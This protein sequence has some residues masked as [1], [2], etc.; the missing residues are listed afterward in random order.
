M[1]RLHHV[2]VHTVVAQRP[3]SGPVTGGPTWKASLPTPSRAVEPWFS[4]TPQ[5]PSVDNR[6]GSSSDAGIAATLETFGSVTGPSVSGHAVKSA[7]GSEAWPAV[8]GGLPVPPGTPAPAADT[9]FF[10]YSHARIALDADGLGR[11]RQCLL[12]V[13]VRAVGPGEQ[14]G[15]QLFAGTE[16]IG[17]DPVTGDD[18]IG[19]LIDVP[20]HGALALDIRLRLVGAPAARLAILGVQGHLL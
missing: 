16:C 11:G 20:D 10:R 1:A 14:A 4:L 9:E 18:R 17:E 19:A 13:A 5:V 8:L 3:S 15:V 6:L 12:L 2:P 7:A